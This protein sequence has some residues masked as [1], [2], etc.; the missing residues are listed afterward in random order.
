M[1]SV[2]LEKTAVKAFMGQLLRENAFDMFEVRTVDIATNIHINFD[3]QLVAEATENDVD[4]VP[5]KPGFSGWENLRPLV[6]G[7][8]KASPKPRHVKIVFSYKADEACNIHPNAAALF[9]NM[10]Y[11][12]DSVTF[13][14]GVA[15]KE[16]IMD[17]SLDTNW[18]DWV[19]GFFARVGMNV[20]DRE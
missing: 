18:D 9:L 4:N 12:N 5:Q 2:E 1:I 3:G 16:F 17:K 19:T 6:Y 15:Q 14:T 10:A 11:E 7:I 20:S 8:I 13:T